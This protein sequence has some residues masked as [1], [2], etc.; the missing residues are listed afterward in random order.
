MFQP[1]SEY[2]PQE[3]RAGIDPEIFPVSHSSVEKWRECPKQYYYDKVARLGRVSGSAAD[4]GTEIHDEL[5][6]LAQSREFKQSTLVQLGDE[7][8]YER[9]R[10][11]ALRIFA[12]LPDFGFDASSVQAESTKHFYL[13]LSDGRHAEVEIRVDLSDV[14]ATEGILKILDYK[15][16]RWV[17]TDLDVED[18][19]A[20]SPKV[21]DANQLKLY[22]W[23]MARILAEEEIFVF[24]VECYQAQVRSGDIL[25]IAFTLEDLEK[26]GKSW[27][28]TVEAMAADKE[29][30]A[31]PG[32][33]CFLCPYSHQC[34]VGAKYIGPGVVMNGTDGKIEWT[35]RVTNDDEYRAA[36]GAASQLSAVVEKVREAARNY[37]KDH[38]PVQI[39]S[40]RHG[41][42]FKQKERIKDVAS[43]IDIAKAH[44]LPLEK[45][46]NF[47]HKT[48]GTY[49]GE[50]GRLRDDDL[51]NLV[52]I[53]TDNEWDYEPMKGKKRIQ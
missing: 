28:R 4:K 15:T 5:Q 24:L 20:D 12:A 14:D 29:F 9:L 30:V 52:E 45:L 47:N 26:F 33:Q 50:R 10:S 40:A 35:V 38:P 19:D 27:L 43:A 41:W 34:E 51:R 25:G 22:G 16:G 11:N 53:I 42:I 23:G 36:I 18:E 21:K 44:G 3:R 48:G 37:S 32:K 39:G 13:R 31:K 1:S 7:Q 17:V 49:I 46:F 8:D 6:S 2:T